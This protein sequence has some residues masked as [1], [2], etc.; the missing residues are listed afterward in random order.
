MARLDYRR[1]IVKQ[2]FRWTT[3]IYSVY[4]YIRRT[5]SGG[6]G[7]RVGCS[8]LPFALGKVFTTGGGFSASGRPAFKWRWGCRWPTHSFGTGG[9]G[10]YPPSEVVCCGGGVTVSSGWR[11]TG[12]RTY[13]FGAGRVGCSTPPFWHD[14]TSGTRPSARLGTSVH[15][16]R[17]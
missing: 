1:A 9:V 14:S 3:H 6:V 4:I 15:A 10:G 2:G 7:E 17:W 8:P 12:R 13:L 16:C 5:G 11:G